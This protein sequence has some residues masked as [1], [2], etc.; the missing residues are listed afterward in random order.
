MKKFIDKDFR[1][2][3]KVFGVLT[4]ITAFITLKAP[5]CIDFVPCSRGNL[6]A[7]Q[8]NLYEG[9][10]PL[11]IKESYFNPKEPGL[12]GGIFSEK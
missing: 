4:G 10:T 7:W 1:A 12:L 11:K 6:A 9:Q 5:S 2:Q 3:G 8:Q